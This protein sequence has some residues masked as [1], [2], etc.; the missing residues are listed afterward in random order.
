MVVS[1]GF[2]SIIVISY[3]FLLNFP[4]FDFFENISFQFNLAINDNP[5]VTSEVKKVM[6]N[7]RLPSKDS[8]MCVEISL[9]SRDVRALTLYCCT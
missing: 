9:K 6:I 1:V 5:D 8:A 7:G 4:N 3:L 2:F